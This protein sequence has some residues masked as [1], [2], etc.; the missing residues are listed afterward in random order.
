MIYCLSSFGQSCI[1]CKGAKSSFHWESNST[2][3]LKKQKINGDVHFDFFF[4][5]FFLQ[6]RSIQW[7]SD[8]SI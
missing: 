2:L 1:V 6:F 4:P 5:S 3:L 7:D 8:T